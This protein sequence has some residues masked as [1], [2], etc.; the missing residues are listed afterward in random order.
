MNRCRSGRGQ[1]KVLTVLEMGDGYPKVFVS[2]RGDSTKIYTVTSFKKGVKVPK[3]KFPSGTKVYN[4]EL[5]F[6]NKKP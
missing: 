5:G 3:R 4:K 6:S 2:E 1:E